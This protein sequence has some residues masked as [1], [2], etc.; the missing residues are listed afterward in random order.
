MRRS[1]DH[2][3]RYHQGGCGRLKICPDKAPSK[4]C[5]NITGTEEQ[6]KKDKI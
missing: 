6:V 5:E 3:G 2:P 4:N 1:A